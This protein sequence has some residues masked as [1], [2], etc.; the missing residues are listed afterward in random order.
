MLTASR[1]VTGLRVA[2]E[3]CP[4]RPYVELRVPDELGS[5]DQLTVVTVSHDQGFSH[6]EESLGGTYEASWSW[7]A[8]SVVSPSNHARAPINDV[9]RNVHA[10]F[11]PK[12]HE[13]V[14]KAS[15]SDAEVRKLVSS[16]R[17]GDLIQ[18]IPRAAFNAWANY[19][20]EAELKVE[21]YAAT[22]VDPSSL[23]TPA[24]LYAPLDKQTKEIR[25]MA[26]DA[27]DFEDA[28]SCTLRTIPMSDSN[29][30]EYNALSYCWGSAG[31][32]RSIQ[33]RVPKQA[34]GQLGASDD[35]VYNVCITWNLFDAIRHIRPKRGV[36]LLWADY[37]CIDQNNLA[38]RAEQVA[39]MRHIYSEASQVHVW[40][41]PRVEVGRWSSEDV[42]A[43]LRTVHERFLGR[44]V[45][46]CLGGPQA[47]PHKDFA[48]TDATGLEIKIPMDDFFSSWWHRCDFAWFRRT[49]VL[50]EVSNARRKP[51]VVHCGRDTLLWP[52]VLRAAKC[53]RRMMHIMPDDRHGF[54]MMPAIFLRLVGTPDGDLAGQGQPQKMPG[55]LEVL[56]GGHDLEA[57]DLRD[58][59]FALLQFGAETWHVEGLP[60]L[61][62]PDYAKT[63]VQTYA[64]FTRWW[65]IQARSLRILSAVHTTRYRGWQQMTA[66]DPPEL[67]TGPGLDD[68]PTWSFW[69]GGTASW[70]EAT[71][72]LSPDTKYRAAGETVPDAQLL[73]L[74]HL[75]E[76][77]QSGSAAATTGLLLRGR[78][79]CTIKSIVPFPVHFGYSE[80]PDDRRPPPRELAAPFI[81]L[82]DPVGARR[83]WL[84]NR[85]G[86]QG[87]MLADLDVRGGHS[88]DGDAAEHYKHA[89]DHD[90][91]PTLDCCSPCYFGADPV[92]PVEVVVDDESSQ[93]AGE[94]LGLC[95]YMSRAGDIVVVLDGGPVP[96]VL[97]ETAKEGSYY[98]VGEC[99]LRGFMNGEALQERGGNM[100]FEA[101][102]F[103][104]I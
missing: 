9:Q 7:F 34:A 96:Y 82:F 4:A 55:I 11:E 40:L 46:G 24:G 101:E 30:I 91:S 50:Q 44:G 86:S 29:H 16:I 6:E 89:R 49:W 43:S 8:L 97:R 69:H 19:V 62:R 13:N 85:E 99:Y 47:A 57:S 20:Y 1:K 54:S 76:T 73:R 58:K 63:T 27:G 31:G 35:E 15:S 71:L 78:R 22:R 83:T 45:D 12:R 87:G 98:L 18:L 3:K 38:E 23:E 25:V 28:I 66:D 94:L 77:S 5:V 48:H 70:A 21:G 14:Y 61:V 102:I 88:R 26:I 93:R 37:V 90:F 75:P 65:I 100:L 80:H 67:G 53:V 92:G 74:P 2:F 39:I 41:G 68:R 17:G 59:I 64:D 81:K 36:Y 72:G 60:P 56:V 32:S 103:T 79:V 10:R 52:V 104:L 51:A 95:P 84:W 42:F 33:V